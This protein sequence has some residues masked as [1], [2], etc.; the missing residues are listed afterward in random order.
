MIPATRCAHRKIT[1]SSSLNR[2]ARQY[3]PAMR[4]LVVVALA[5]C[6]S[7][8]KDYQPPPA[9]PKKP[10]E[11]PPPK[12]KIGPADFGSCTLK[13][14]GAYAAEETIA[15]DKKSAS[16]KYWQSEDERGATP[17]PA[18][19]INCNGDKLRLS[20]VSAPHAEV[21]YGVKDY[22]L[23]GKNAELVLL[24]RAGDQLSDFRGHIE[25]NTFDSKHV[26]G[27]IAVTAK[28]GRAGRRV[29]I[30]GSFDYAC[31]GMAGCR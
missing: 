21:P 27:T 7:S 26:T 19:T 20:I 15:G 8:D 24:G 3:S 17:M 29:A 11:P 23:T 12:K 25:I 13:A 16:S 4:F 31:P 22:T 10:A 1:S 30:D 2:T 18:L 5:A 6:T 28:S 9:P 14:S